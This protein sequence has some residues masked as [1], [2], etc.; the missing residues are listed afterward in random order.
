MQDPGGR[1]PG[2]FMCDELLQRSI[3]LDRAEAFG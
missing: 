2:F 3:F 1:P